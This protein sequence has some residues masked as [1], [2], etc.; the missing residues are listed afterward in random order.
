MKMINSRKWAP[1][2]LET[3]DVSGIAT[4]YRRKRT[5]VSKI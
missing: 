1:V 4:M 3:E 2:I 5:K